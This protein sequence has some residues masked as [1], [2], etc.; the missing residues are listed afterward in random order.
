MKLDI[1]QKSYSL[2]WDI[3]KDTT[4]LQMQAITH[5]HWGQYTANYRQRL[6]NNNNNN[7]KVTF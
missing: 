7:N 4:R 6:N 3:S 5:E 1:L 2:Y